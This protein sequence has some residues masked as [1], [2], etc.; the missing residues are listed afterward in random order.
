MRTDRF[1]AR[2]VAARTARELSQNELAK[3]VGL[4]HSA[5]RGYEREEHFPDIQTLEMIADAL[6]MS[7]A[8]LAFG[9]CVQDPRVEF[10]RGQLER[11]LEDLRE[12]QAERQ[13]EHPG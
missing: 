3:R 13:G 5:I 10:V 9:D 11:L 1:A 4:S 8:Q 12:Q 7:P 2:L 6:T